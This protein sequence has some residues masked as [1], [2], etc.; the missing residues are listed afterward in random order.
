MGR[1]QHTKVTTVVVGAAASI[2]VVG[3]A[4]SSATPSVDVDGGATITAQVSGLEPGQACRIDAAGL[5][6]PWRPVGRDGT[7]ELN[8][9]PVPQ[10]RHDATIVCE[11]PLAGKA[12]VHTVGHEQDVFTGRW[13]P[14]YEFLQHHRLEL[15]TPRERS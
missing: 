5:E 11:N 15:L 1:S 2:L 8:S 14:A 7:V 12:S 9:G 10:G 4:T 13:A 3:A 6:M